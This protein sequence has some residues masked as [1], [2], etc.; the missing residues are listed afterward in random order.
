M[1]WPFRKR[2]SAITQLQESLAE[3]QKAAMFVPTPWAVARQMLELA[4][5][6]PEDTV[7][8]LGSGDGR[9]PIL[10]AQEFGCKAVGIEK[11]A[12][13]FRYS[14]QRVADL[15]LRD[16]VA[17][18]NANFFEADFRP[19][20]VVTLY[21]LS[22]VNGHLQSRL[23]SHLRQGSRVVAL[24]FEVPGWRACRTAPVKSEGNVDYTLHLYVR[25]APELSRNTN[26]DVAFAGAPDP[27]EARVGLAAVGSRS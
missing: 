25:A 7:Y 6:G 13:L 27:R 17:F 22:A 19:A 10:A 8:D 12:E 14:Q 26:R 23:A 3:L 18:Q 15:N 16:Q 9:I 4:Q 11:D 20:T 2:L 24:D 1:K 5:V 21:L